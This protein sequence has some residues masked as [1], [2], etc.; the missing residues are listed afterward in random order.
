MSII[1]AN[2]WGGY[3]AAPAAVGGGPANSLWGL[4]VPTTPGAPAVLTPGNTGANAAG[5]L[6]G[7]P[8]AGFPATSTFLRPV[9]ASIGGPAMANT[10]E[11]VTTSTAGAASPWGGPVAAANAVAADAARA[12]AA[13]MTT[14]SFGPLTNAVVAPVAAV[15]AAAG[16]GA[17]VPAYFVPGARPVPET[18][19][20]YIAGEDYLAATGMLPLP[21][22]GPGRFLASWPGSSVITGQGSWNAS[23]WTPCGPWLVGYGAPGVCGCGGAGCGTFVRPP[24]LF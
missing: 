18:A 12:S 13:M 3:T 24:V 17:P 9:A 15:A 8:A 16:A 5:G 22:V 1:R 6:P 20:G 21:D 2:P 23:P 4:Q 7:G 10:Y 19:A 14:T 11:V